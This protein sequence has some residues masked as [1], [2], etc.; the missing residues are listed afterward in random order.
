VLQSVMERSL[1][2]GSPFGR[3][4][5][6]MDVAALV[7]AGRA[8]LDERA[9]SFSQLG[10]LLH[11]RWPDRDATSLAQAIRGLVPLVQVPPRGIWGAGGQVTCA[12]AETWLGRPLDPDPSPDEIV[13]RYLAAFGPASV[14]DVQLWSGLTRL[15]EVVEQQRPRLRTFRDESGQELFDVPCAPLPDPD[16][17]APS[18]FLPEFDNV[19]FSHVD[20]TRIIPRDHHKRVIATRVPAMVLNDGYVC[21]SWKIQRSKESATLLVDL[22]EPLSKED[23]A[24]VAEEGTKLLA[25][26]AADT[27]THDVRFAPSA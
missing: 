26:A 22:F 17:P 4:I 24:A 7:E 9:R 8:L 5:Q 1:Y 18:R 21:G 11:E 3:R 19:L 6:G 16:T 14:R 27:G 23:R 20:R 2:V 15:G 12:T 25:F 10:K 13:L